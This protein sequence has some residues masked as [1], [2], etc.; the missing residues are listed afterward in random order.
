MEPQQQLE[1]RQVANQ[2]NNQAAN[3]PPSS[4]KQQS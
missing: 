1:N 3:Q 4:A 2:D